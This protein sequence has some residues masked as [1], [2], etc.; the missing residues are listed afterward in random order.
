[1]PAMKTVARKWL[2]ALALLAASAP[3]CEGRAQAQLGKLHVLLVLDT[4]STLGDDPKKDGTIL[5][6]ILQ[7]SIGA[8]FLSIQE[9]E[10]SNARKSAVL[11]H[12]QN[13]PAGPN[14]TVMCFLSCHGGTTR[15]DL[16]ARDHILQLS[17]SGQVE[18][19]YRSELRTAMKQ[20][21]ARLLVLLSDAC[22]TFTPYPPNTDLGRIETKDPIAPDKVLDGARKLFFDSRGLVDMNAATEGLYAFSTETGGI[23]T[24]ALQKSFDK[25][26]KDSTVSWLQLHNDLF[27]RT[28]AE[29][30]QW[31]TSVREA[32]ER[33]GMWDPNGNKNHK[34]LS[35]QKTQYPQTFFLPDG[36]KLGVTT[37]GTGGNG[38][39]VIGLSPDGKARAAG[40]KVGDMIVGV[41]TTE[42]MTTD[43]WNKVIDPLLKDGAREIGLT[44][45]RNNERVTLRIR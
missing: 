45:L 26:E 1:M 7:S 25:Y 9:L 33:V 37:R 44:V 28:D 5:R 39:E 36:M 4:K 42:V 15:S 2:A 27:G 12:Y 35:D 43:Q 16:P 13:H 23:F 34:R 21:R 24:R 19:V 31:K 3:L 29:F 32:H 8:N 40:V 20:S 41:D 30:A 6:S 18:N 17:G 38:L 22:G 11:A 14:D 10:G